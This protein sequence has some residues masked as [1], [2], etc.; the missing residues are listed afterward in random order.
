PIQDNQRVKK[1]DLLFKIDDRQYRAMLLDAQSRLA[2]LDAQIRLTG[3]TVKAQ[4]Y[5]AQSVTAAVARAQA[6]LQQTTSSRQRLEPL[7]SQ[8]FASQ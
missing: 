6:L 1:G 3:R 4:E 8:G 5:N 2:A 7:V